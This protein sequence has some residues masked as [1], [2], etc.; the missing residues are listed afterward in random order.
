MNTTYGKNIKVSLFGASHAPAIG[1]TVEGLPAGETVDLQELQAFLE[2]RAPGRDELSTARREPDV[3]EFLSGLTD[4]RTDGKPLKAVI[5]NTDARSGDYESIK[6]TPRPGHADYTARVKY[7][8]GFDMAGGGPFSGRMTAPLCVAGG[9]AL[10]ILA[11][12]GITI[13]AQVISAGGV[14][15]NEAVMRAAIAAA[16]DEG[17][18]VGGIVECMAEGVPAGL[19][20]PFFE[21]LE[22]R[23]ADAVYGIPAVKGVDFGAGFSAAYMTGSECND[24]FEV[25]D[26]RI[27]TKTN[28]CG[29]ILGGISTGM[30]IVFR[31]AFKPTP[32][33]AKE[34]QTVNLKTLE[35][36]TISV[37][38]RHDPCIVFRAVPVVEAA[39]A[40][41]ILD[42]M[43][44]PSDGKTLQGCR[45][46]MDLVNAEIVRLFQERMDLSAQIAE[47]KKEQDLP[48]FDAAR[49]QEI[50]DKVCAGLPDDLQDYGKELFRTLMGVSKDYQRSKTEE[51]ETC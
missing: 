46:Q 1:V 35:N 11:R 48:V 7:G 13:H 20:G 28:N 21:G 5:R 43:L 10:Q 33:I 9:I 6:D 22:S 51:D 24:P 12:K 8:E 23:I 45:E 49:E 40:L 4:S 36:T 14:S 17:D 25:Q 31:A 27:V 26:G 29:G 47:I 50:L 16:R 32:S 39:A 38:G 3:P 15:G 30:P 42:A 44:D 34:Q 37:P 18:S 2:R 19:G 41:A